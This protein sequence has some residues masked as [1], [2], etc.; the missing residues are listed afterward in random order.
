MLFEGD[1]MKKLNNGGW[2]LGMMIGL[3][4]AFAIFL[5]IIVILSHN[6]GLD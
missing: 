6:V 3:L 4:V 1:D 5:L 2:S